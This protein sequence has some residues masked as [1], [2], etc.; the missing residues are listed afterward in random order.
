MLITG[1][2][3]SACCTCRIFCKETF[4]NTPLH[5]T[6]ML[7]R[8]CSGPT[9]A[10]HGQPGVLQEEK[11]HAHLRPPLR[12]RKQR[13]ETQT[14]TEHAEC[15]WSILNYSCTPGVSTISTVIC[16][17]LSCKVLKW[18]VCDSQSCFMLLFYFHI[19][20]WKQN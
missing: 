4:L 16:Q 7:Y 5:G 11:H 3:S 14:R 1:P 17:K 9:S 2:S 13:E 15:Y 20:I 8:G 19:N 18:H 6:A 12:H 10:I